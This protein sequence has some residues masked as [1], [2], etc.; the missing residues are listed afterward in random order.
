MT[1]R[2]REVSRFARLNGG[3]MFVCCP[4]H[5]RF[6]SWVNIMPGNIKSAIAGTCR[7]LDPGNAERW[8]ASFA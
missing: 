6:R 1:P 7:K 5:E 2:R 8:L 3:G 4:A